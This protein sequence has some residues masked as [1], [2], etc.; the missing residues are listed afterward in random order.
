MRF[1]SFIAAVIVLAAGPAPAF[2]DKRVALV[3]GNAAYR[4]MAQLQNP[5]NDAA[6]VAAALRRLDFEAIAAT[7]LDRRA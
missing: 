3:I 7:D 1:S 2:A 6:D 4:S 5:G